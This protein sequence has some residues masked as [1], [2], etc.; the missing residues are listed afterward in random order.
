MK[1]VEPDA[2]APHAKPSRPHR[3]PLLTQLLSLFVVYV[4]SVFSDYVRRHY[5]KRQ[6]D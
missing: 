4:L 3:L 6:V 2:G 1:K 5:F